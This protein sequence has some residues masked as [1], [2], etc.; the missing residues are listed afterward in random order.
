QP[1]R[2]RQHTLS[3][4]LSKITTRTIG[5]IYATRTRMS[6]PVQVTTA[7][8]RHNIKR[9]SRSGYG[10]GGGGGL[11]GARMGGGDHLPL[12][13]GAEL[14]APH[15]PSLPHH[16]G[17][18]AR[19]LIQPVPPDHHLLLRVW[20]RALPEQRLLPRCAYLSDACAR[21]ARKLKAELGKDSKNL[22]V[23]VD[24]HEE[25][26]DDFSGI[27]IWWYASKRQ[28]KANVISLYPGGDEKRFYR[29]VFYRWHRDLV[30]D[31]YLRFI[32]GEGRAV[33]VK[34]RQRRLFTNN[35]SGS[36]NPY[37][38]KSVWSH[39]P[40]KHPATF[41]TLAMHPDEK[42]AVTD[43]LMAFQESKEYYAKV[44]KAWKQGTSFTDRPALAS[45]R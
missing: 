8:N 13:R 11:R 22:L 9:S 29:V 6:S 41:D 39:V 10:S 30:V 31:S 3:F 28:S 18:Q 20:R 33:T 24:D 14:R 27:T 7:F 37:R 40:F 42:E 4:N 44:G 23:S 17:R 5:I 16:L 26:T 12:V 38:G 19:S 32:L 1:Q 15:L 43:N 35:A 2:P 36:W 45:P 21:H 34:N 25:V